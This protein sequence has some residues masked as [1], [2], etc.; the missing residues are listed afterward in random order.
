[1]SGE[2]D[3]RGKRMGKI[4]RADTAGDLGGQG[5]ESQLEP[6]GASQAQEAA[7][8]PAWRWA[9]ALAHSES[10]TQ[11]AGFTGQAPLGMW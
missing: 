5:G 7:G 2:E 11:A 4:S 9:R 1:M 6:E 10:C 8:A 3:R